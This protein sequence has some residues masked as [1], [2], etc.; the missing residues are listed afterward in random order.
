MVSDKDSI[1]GNN[2]K[3][4]KQNQKSFYDF[5]DKGVFAQ[6]ENIIKYYWAIN[7][8]FGI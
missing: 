4:A 2:C 3:G 6:K 8:I 1:D 5:E 7:S